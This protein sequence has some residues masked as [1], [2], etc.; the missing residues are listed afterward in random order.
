MAFIRRV[1]I[2]SE[3]DAFDLPEIAVAA[4]FDDQPQIVLAGEVDRRDN[5]TRVV[6]AATA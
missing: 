5:V 1:Q 3:S 6:S 4:A 2:S